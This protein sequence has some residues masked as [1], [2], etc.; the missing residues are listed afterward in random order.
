MSFLFKCILRLNFR[1]M[2]KN[3]SDRSRNT[4]I[5][6]SLF[7]Y[8]SGGF[9]LKYKHFKIVIENQHQTI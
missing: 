8:Y 9:L 5:A 6:D 7:R 3:R 4:S 2:T 1:E